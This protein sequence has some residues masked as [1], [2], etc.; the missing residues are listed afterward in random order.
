M[1]CAVLEVVVLWKAN[2]QVFFLKVVEILFETA[3]LFDVYGKNNFP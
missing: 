3:P 1:Y 2:I